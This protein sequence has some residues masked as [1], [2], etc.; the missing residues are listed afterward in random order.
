MSK[1][2]Y[3]EVL[4]VNRSA[5]AEE[6][7][8]G[9]RKTALKYH[10][11]KN[12]DDPNAEERFKEAAEAYEVLSDETKRSQYDRYGHEGVH[13]RSSGRGG[14]SS[15]ED[16]LRDFGDIFGGSSP[17]ESFFGRTE[18]RSSRV[19]G[20]DLRIRLK[21]ILEE[22]AKGVEKKIKVR[23]MVVDPR[24]RFGPCDTCGGSGEVR[25]AVQTLLG[26]MVSSST[27][28]AC[29][30]VGQRMQSRPNGVERSG[31]TPKEEMLSIR[32]PAGVS[33]GVQLSLQGKGNEAPGGVGRPGDLL[34]LIDE[35]PDTR[36][37]RDGNDICYHLGLSISEAALGRQLTVPTLSGNVKIKIQSG[38]QSG[39]ILRLRGKGIRDLQD[40]GTGDQL[41]HIHVWT[42]KRLSLDEKEMLERLSR[43]PN[44]RPPPAGPTAYEN[45]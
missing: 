33:E 36:F 34:I 38:T 31:L 2:D 23:R 22:I 6:V 19:K 5:T 1:R 35:V 32:I 10:P 7:K 9:Y 17:F 24:V 4:G 45:T 20:T 14:H 37:S 26:Q 18:R 27:C 12:P 11:D 40:E 21:V 41:I 3:Y 42:P 8:K 43:S 29:G 30:G 44:F 13:A 39:K 25:K 15:V 28:P 16:I